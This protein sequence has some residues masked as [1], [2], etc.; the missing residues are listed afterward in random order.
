MN[1]GK[2]YLA[3]IPEPHTILGLRLKPFSAGH[4]LLLHRTEN[5]FVTNEDVNDEQLEAHLATAIFICAHDFAGGLASL[6]S[7]AT[8]A[9]MTRWKRK[10]G[11]FN[12]A[13]K[14]KA[15]TAYLQQGSTVPSYL[16]K[17]DSV[18]GRIDLPTVQ[19]VKVTL[20]KAFGG[21]T[22]AEFLNRPWGLSL[23]DFVTIKATEGAVDVVDSD[24]IANAQ[25]VADEMQ[26]RLNGGKA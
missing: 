3:A 22:E 12:L 20:L 14:V 13:E 19:L 18:G 16:S 8:L 4:I 26:A 2:Y 23:W 25:A 10:I 7:K 11:A 21:M 5:A 15:F 1:D 17:H 6:D 24:A 9:F